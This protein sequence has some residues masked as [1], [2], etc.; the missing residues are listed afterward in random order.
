MV[1]PTGLAEAGAKVVIANL[2]GEAGQKTAGAICCD[3]V[4][5]DMSREDEIIGLGQQVIRRHGRADV[6]VNNAGTYPFEPALEMTAEFW[7][8]SR[9]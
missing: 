2:D 1:L 8:R 5:T 3:F 9:L 4:R 6:L 7:D